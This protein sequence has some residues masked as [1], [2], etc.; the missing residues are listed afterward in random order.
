MNEPVEEYATTTGPMRNEVLQIVHR[1]DQEYFKIGDVD[2]MPVFFM[3]IVS[4]SNHWMFVASNGG[5]TAGRV[6]ADSAL[7]PYCTDDKIIDSCEHVGSKTIIQGRRNG[8]TYNWEP[9]SIQSHHFKTER[10]IYKHRLGNSII[11]EERNLD[12]NLCFF[13]EWSTS[14]RYGFVKT[15][16][17]ENHSNE[18]HELRILD[19]LQYVLPAGVESELQNTF[20]N[21][22]DAYKHSEL[23]A[24]TGLGIFAL[25]ARITDRAEPSE[26]LFANTV[27]SY[28][29][30]KPLV[31]LSTKQIERFRN[32]YAITTEH[33]NKGSRGA[34]LISSSITLPAGDRSTW[35]CIADVNQS[36]S[37]VIELV[38]A[39]TH[40]ENVVCELDAD[41]QRGSEALLSL[42]MSV[43]GIQLTG[44]PLIDSRHYSNA[45]FNAMRGGVFPK[46]YTI[47]KRDFIEYVRTCNIPLHDELHDAL[48]HFPEEFTLRELRKEIASIGNQSLTRIA[49]EYLPLTFSRRHGDPSRPWNRFSINTKNADG[50]LRYDYQGNWRDIFQNWE[51]LAHSHPLFLES[52]VRKFLNATTIDGYNPYR[53]QKSGFDWE[54]IEP[55]NPWSYIG[56]W[57][58]HQIIYLLKLLEL[59]RDTQP[60]ALNDLMSTEGFA[61]A[62]VPYRLKPY[63]DIVR[64][65]K[66]TIV[67]D[68]ELHTALMVETAK[69]GSDGALVKSSSG[70]TLHV[71]FIEK[72]LVTLLARVTSYVP[73]GGIWMNTQRPEW[74]DANN[75]LVGN[76]LSMVTLCYLHRF[77]AF[78]S[79]L[80]EHHNDTVFAISNEVAEYLTSTRDV[81]MHY[82]LHATEYSDEMRRSMMDELGVIGSTYRAATYASSFT[83]NVTTVTKH[84]LTSFCETVLKHLRSSISKNLRSD[85]LYH[86]Y[87]LLSLTPGKASITR[88]PAMLEG[89]VAVLSS[90]CVSS[91]DALAL[92]KSLSSSELFRADQH[93]YM[94][95]PMKRVPGFLSKNTLSKEMVETSRLLKALIVD[96]NTA[97][98]QRNVHGG[99]HFNGTLTN[100][101]EFQE[102]LHTLDTKYHDLLRSENDHLLDLYESVFHHKQFTGR[103]GSFFAYEGI[104]SIYWHMVSKLR[105]AVQEIF[106]SAGNDDNQSATTSEL[107]VMYGAVCDGIGVHKSPREYGA[108]PTDPYSHT[109]LSRGAQQPGMTGQVKEDV[110]CR[111]RELGVV[112]D[113]GMI[114]FVPNMV[115]QHDFLSSSRAIDF[116]NIRGDVQRI[117]LDEGMLFFSVCQTPVTY[118]LGEESN[119]TIHWNNGDVHTTPS[120]V[121]PPDVSNSIFARTGDID[122]IHVALDRSRLCA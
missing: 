49:L 24:D 68:H 93:S 38:D 10:N 40:A 74:N 102:A 1:G 9:F 120:L 76:G 14:D 52:M 101:R 34:Y 96:G 95:Y 28:G 29:M 110:I 104:G 91:S 88:L 13:Y 47:E 20:S 32:G 77:I 97:I 2:T 84:T 37:Q 50:T 70:E 23:H 122:V 111:M 73:D 83:G 27:W 55:H 90:G 71:H 75:A 56:Y 63:D 87:N 118:E 64:N 121:L 69:V 39:I 62:C 7:F 18:T 85:G 11:F 89:Q 8:T 82:P 115:S 15:S 16:T 116:Q 117:A 59:F 112:Y 43:D 94:L 105:Y 21:L 61:F 41:V 31:L 46:N 92:L 6:N 4:D 60:G 109:P 113:H 22:V 44:D 66:S 65:P 108:F 5:L 53:V 86:S 33:E 72:I 67:F 30:K 35:K 103:S 54:V 57:G 42:V 114:Q 106:Q 81:F 36:Q 25:S 19:G 98:I 58:D 100:I 79:D 99:F 119:I 80:L 45:L 17:L 26:A 78:F 107:L 3:S 51:A 12:L 48:S